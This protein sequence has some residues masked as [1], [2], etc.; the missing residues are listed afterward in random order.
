MFAALDLPRWLTLHALVTVLALLAYVTTAHALRQRR[1][2]AS[3]IAWV[4]FI[5]L[6]PYAALPLFLLFGSRKLARPNPPVPRPPHG[7]S[8]GWAADT[9]VALGQPGPGRCVALALHEDGVA[10]RLALFAVIDGATRSL[11]VCSFILARDAFGE[12]VLARLCARAHAGLRVRLMVDGVGYLMARHA[13]LH[14]L[15]EAGGAVLRFVPP[16]RSPLRG[17]SNLRNHRKLVVADAGLPGGRL[18]CGGRNLAAEYFEGLPGQAPWRDLSV[19]LRGAAVEQAAAMFERDWVFAGGRPGGDTAVSQGEIERPG[20]G[21]QLLGSGPDQRE[22]TLLALL[23]TAVYRAERRIALVTPYFVP[24]PALL[25]AL[26]LAAQRGVAVELLMPARSNHRLSDLARGRALRSLARA[27]ARVWFVPGMHHGKLVVVDEVL[28]LVGSANL[29]SRSLLLNYEVML[30]LHAP[31]DTARFAAWFERER[32]RAVAFDP[33]RA[34]LWRDLGEGLL[35][36]LAF[37][38]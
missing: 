15:V 38:L 28:A 10:A 16:L 36:W 23:L 25:T 19:D 2:P 11:D 22:D 27:G 24:E 14:R 6:L 1:P 26:V 18:W 9:L 21:A 13:P 32:T 20:E 3:A 29:D 33:P 30:A 35:L 8:L 34:G 31:A 4:L 37:Q 5:V 12:A 7:E 17:R